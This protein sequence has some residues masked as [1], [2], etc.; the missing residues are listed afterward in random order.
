MLSFSVFSSSIG[1]ESSNNTCIDAII[2]IFDAGIIFNHPIESSELM[3]VF[4][5]QQH[6]AVWITIK[7]IMS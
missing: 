1:I 3:H 2:G 4:T 7:P 5:P 6:S